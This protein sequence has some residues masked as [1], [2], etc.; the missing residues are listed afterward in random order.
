[1]K[2]AIMSIDESRSAKKT[3]I[4]NTISAW[5]EIKFPCVNGHNR[6]ELKKFQLENPWVWMSYSRT[7]RD[8]WTAKAGELGVWYSTINAWKWIAVR[9]NEEYLIVLED[10]ALLDPAF[11]FYAQEIIDN[12]PP[13][14]DFIT[15]FVPPNQKEDYYCWTPI[16]P[17]DG[18]PDLKHRIRVP[19]DGPDQWKVND[20]VAKAY[21][22]YSNVAMVYS[23][24][25]AQNLMAE[26]KRRGIFTPVDCFVY[27]IAN[28]EEI[29]GYAPHPKYKD[30][31]SVD[32]KAPTL[33]HET[34]KV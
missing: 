34:E 1:M 16:E 5:K 9:P 18:F 21:P 29:K 22:N 10:D 33:I 17:D 28:L 27:Q 30:F 32:W 20:I 15:L 19:P 6:E 8:T 25:G 23:S 14:F 7:H 26:V 24:K 4:R 3:A 2:Y 31:V 12:T 13:D 11:D